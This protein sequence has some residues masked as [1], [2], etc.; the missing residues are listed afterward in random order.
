MCNGPMP[1]LS[2]FFDI[3]DCRTKWGAKVTLSFMVCG[4]CRVATPISKSSER[5][6]DLSLDEMLRVKAL[7]NERGF[8][9]DF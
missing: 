3:P 2:R 8:I 5:I 6:R 9:S 1:R 4:A 7:L